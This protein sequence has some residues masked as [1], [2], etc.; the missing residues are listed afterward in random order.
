MSADAPA[1]VP[2]PVPG[3]VLVTFPDG[4]TGH[5]S[6]RKRE[7]MLTKGWLRAEDQPDYTPPEKTTRPGAKRRKAEP[8][9]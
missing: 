7:A 8:S 1:S 4:S 5:L 3:L 6:P 9:D 2:D